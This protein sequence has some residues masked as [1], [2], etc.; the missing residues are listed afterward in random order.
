MTPSEPPH[1]PGPTRY[2]GSAP[3]PVGFRGI[4]G[5]LIRPKV[6]VP[7]PAAAPETSTH[8][9]FTT[10]GAHLLSP[11]TLSTTGPRAA[12]CPVCLV[13]AA[14]PP[15]GG[16]VPVRCRSCGTEF[17]ATDGSPPPAPAPAPPPPSPIAPPSRPT[18]RPA[19]S[20][21]PRGFTSDVRT[22]A[23]GGRR[24]TCPRC[25]GAD[26]KVPRGA[27][28]AVVLR[29]PVCRGPFLVNLDGK[30]AP[31]APAPPP[32]PPPP[33]RG[34]DK[35]PVVPIYGA[36]YS[37]VVLC[38]RCW[39]RTPAPGTGSRWLRF[40][41]AGCGA[42]FKADTEADPLPLAAIPPALAPAPAVPWKATGPAGAPVAV[43][44]GT[45]S[46]GWQVPCPKCGVH[47][48]APADAIGWV[49]F[50]CSGC[51][52]EFKADS[53]LPRNPW[54]TRVA[55]PPP[56]PKLDT[57]PRVPARRGA[58]SRT[59]SA[60]HCPYCG[61]E[62]PV[63]HEPKPDRLVPTTCSSCGNMF[64]ADLRLSLWGKIRRL[65]GGG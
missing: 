33:A 41:C 1:S 45:K 56:A 4:G 58:F 35:T 7:K 23:D 51:G 54:P 6:P 34:S 37:A 65:F 60:A 53:A 46:A 21:A 55:P 12:A 42:K 38:P 27:T 63:D 2:Y 48:G 49:W 13:V 3:W 25:L 44:Y 20:D 61:R 26:L 62:V 24:V 29:C 31:P 11:I 10:H 32:S 28:V 16:W 59:R 15:T 9:A 36:G 43:I 5:H 47:A 22:T 8:P 52:T 39:V 19:D 57:A 14:L 17:V 40:T 18:P 50:R 64:V 30:P